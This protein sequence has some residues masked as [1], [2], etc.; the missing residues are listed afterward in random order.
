[1]LLLILLNDLNE[2]HYGRNKG[3]FIF[4]TCFNCIIDVIFWFKL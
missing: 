1:L 3:I 2:P 4:S